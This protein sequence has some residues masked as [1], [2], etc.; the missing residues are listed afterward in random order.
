MKKDSKKNKNSYEED[1]NEPDVW[2]LADEEEAENEN[3]AE[4]KNSSEMG[5]MLNERRQSLG[6]TNYQWSDKSD[7]NLVYI[8]GHARELRKVNSAFKRQLI[9][10][11]SLLY[12]L[13]YN[14]LDFFKINIF[15]KDYS[16]D[17]ILGSGENH[18]SEINSTLVSMTSDLNKVYKNLVKKRTEKTLNMNKRIT[19]N[20]YLNQNLEKIVRNYSIA[21]RKFV[22][23][24]PQEKGYFKIKNL[25]DNLE[26]KRDVTIHNLHLNEENVI[27]YLK[28]DPK[29]EKIEK[30]TSIYIFTS[31]ELVDK[32]KRVLDFIRITRPIYDPLNKQ[33]DAIKALFNSVNQIENYTYDVQ[34]IVGKGIREAIGIEKNPRG[35][36]NQYKDSNKLLYSILSD[37]SN[38]YDKRLIE[39]NDKFNK[40]LTNG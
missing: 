1:E 9:Q 33:S 5:N 34:N 36:V 24:R 11:K 40:Y 28:I 12:K 3:A 23:M 6:L 39:T 26:R 19:E 2:K 17:E 15:G 4:V 31:E 30:I 32:T 25:V 20:D 29:L 22:S 35:L 27:D 16:I 10:R 14:T 38:A 8:V 37:V 18:L 21:K 13:T 7:G